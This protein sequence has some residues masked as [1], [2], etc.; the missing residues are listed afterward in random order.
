MRVRRLLA[1]AAICL[2]VVALTGCSG[3]TIR[4]AVNG[5]DPAV[6]DPA[7]PTLRDEP[8]ADPVNAKAAALTAWDTLTGDFQHVWSAM[9]ADPD[10]PDTLAEAQVRFANVLSGGVRV[11]QWEQRDQGE[12]KDGLRFCLVGPAATYFTFA[13]NATGDGQTIMFKRTWGTGDCNYDAGDIIAELTPASSRQRDSIE[14]LRNDTLAVAVAVE[15]WATDHPGRLPASTKPLAA[16]GLALST[17]NAVESYEVTGDTYRVCV[18]HTSGAWGTLRLAAD[19]EQHL[20]WPVQAVGLRGDCRYK[21]MSDEAYAALLTSLPS[22]EETVIK[23]LDLA[24]QVPT[25]LQ[26]PLH[27]VFHLT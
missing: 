11:A 2:S 3:D 21:E 24:E 6:T 14:S 27:E 15:T 22:R 25:L 8:D 1:T 12:S 10:K 5:V 20:S 9:G 26:N 18:R 4:E 13:A 7:Q 17:G 19:D 23:G 16:Y